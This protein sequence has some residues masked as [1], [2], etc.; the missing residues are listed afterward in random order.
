MTLTAKKPASTV[1]DELAKVSSAAAKRTEQAKLSVLGLLAPPENLLLNGD[2]RLDQRQAGGTAAVTANDAYGPDGF[3]TSRN[4]ASNT[5]S[6]QRVA[7]TAGQTDVPGNP[8]YYLRN[9]FVYGTSA[10]GNYI[11]LRQP[12]MNLRQFTGQTVTLSFYA[13]C[14]T[15]LDLSVE[16]SGNFG[17]GGSPS[18]GENIQGKKVTLTP[19]WQRIDL[20]F[21]VPAWGD[22]TFGTNEDS[23]LILNLFFAA[24]SSFNTRLSTLGAQNGTIDIAQAGLFIG[25]MREHPMPFKVYSDLDV[26]AQAQRFYVPVAADFDYAIVP[27]P[28]N[29]FA[30]S[31]RINFPVPMHGV[32][33]F[34]RSSVSEAA[35][36]SANLEHLDNTK[37][38]Y[39]FV[40][41]ANTNGTSVFKWTA[42]Y[43][44]I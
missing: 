12:I 8:R 18:S 36:T 22:K 30:N 13:R 40:A 31:Y 1:Q 19:A 32:P 39:S 25:D 42:E 44:P 28:A 9:T 35:L 41:N 5:L 16:L 6:V 2:F 4:G 10:S 26:I 27:A 43:D 24:G 21:H 38:V 3:K 34:T 17:S 7:F 23:H 37:A 33:T 15:S 29:T 20:V 14:A 11:R